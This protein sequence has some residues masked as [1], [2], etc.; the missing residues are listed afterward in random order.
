M[1][2]V[3]IIMDETNAND[4]ELT[5]GSTNVPTTYTF[6]QTGYTETQVRAATQ[7]MLDYMKT[8]MIFSVEAGLATT[9]V[10]NPEDTT[11]AH[12]PVVCI[13]NGTGGSGKDTFIS[14]VNQ[15]CSAMRLTSVNEVYEVADKFIDYTAPFVGEFGEL[16]KIDPAG[17]RDQKTDRFRTFMSD[18]KT[19]WTKF[20]DGPTICLLGEL[21]TTV[22]KLLNA[23]EEYDVVFMI[24]REPVEI[25]KIKNYIIQNMG[26]MCITALVDGQV[27]PDA[28]T[29]YADRGV[30]KYEYDLVIHNEYNTTTMLE[31]QAMLFATLLTQANSAIGLK[32]TVTAA[33]NA[34]AEFPE[35]SNN[36]TS[37]VSGSNDN[38][39][40][41]VTGSN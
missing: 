4:I 6:K 25:D 29:N 11:S 36:T 35:T 31:L 5:S 21:K 2:E 17:E 26:I 23:G 8:N 3:N 34:T 13:L 37:T 12:Y 14:A 33:N 18:L 27:S 10:M 20:C 38:R 24:I 1:S 40:S 41:A 7:K 39:S 19:A 28:Y 22:E 16:T 32:A 9:V 15:H 30:D